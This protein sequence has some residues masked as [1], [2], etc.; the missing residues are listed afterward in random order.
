MITKSDYDTWHS[1][2]VTKAFF[3][4]LAEQISQVKEVLSVQAGLDPNE[5]NFKRGY[6]RACQDVLLFRIDD[7]QEAVE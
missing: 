7:L 3:L 2:P 1:D 4:A 5:D 6:V